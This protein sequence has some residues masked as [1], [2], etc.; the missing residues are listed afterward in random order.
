MLNLSYRTCKQAAVLV[1]IWAGVAA[2]VG[3]QTSNQLPP[4]FAALVLKEAKVSAPGFAKT[5]ATATITFSATKPF[6]NK[7]FDTGISYHFELHCFADQFW[8]RME[9]T[10]RQLL[11]Q[12]VAR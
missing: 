10:Y 5:S 11:E 1:L 4:G 2:I 9:S 8:K 12:D 7:R 3:A 6:K